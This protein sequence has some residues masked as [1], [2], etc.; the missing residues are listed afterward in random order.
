LAQGS[1]WGK[2][3]WDLGDLPGQLCRCWC[4]AMG[5]IASAPTSVLDEVKLFQSLDH[6]DRVKTAKAMTEKTYEP[7]EVIIRQN[8][9][10]DSFFVLETGT[11]KVE[12]DGTKVAELGHHEYFGEVALLRDETR[13]A[14]V[15]AITKVRLR[16]ISRAQFDE[17]KLKEKLRF[18]K[19][20]AVGGRGGDGKAAKPPSS[21]TP[22]ERE[23]MANA[24]KSNANLKAMF[25]LDE[26][27]AKINQ[28]IDVMWSEKVLKGKEIMTQGD[29]TAD[30]FY[31]VM[32]GKFA[33]QQTPGTGAE[34]GISV[35]QVGEVGP[36]GSFGE[37]ALMYAARRAATV[38]AMEDSSVMII[39]RFNFKDILQKSSTEDVE[40]YIGYLN[41]AEFLVSLK[42]E[43]KQLLARAVT[44]MTFKKDELILQEGEE[45][46]CFYILIEGTV[47]CLISGNEVEELKAGSDKADKIPFFGEKAL[48]NNE[49]RKATVKVTSQS[50]TALVVD[51]TSFDMLVGP[52]QALNARGKA[53]TQVVEKVTPGVPQKQF[54]LILRQNLKVLGLLGCGGFGTV[55]LVEHIKDQQTYALKGLS[56]GYVVKSGMQQSVMSEKNVQLQCNSDFII[57]LFETYN[58]QQN[59]YLLLEL[60]L[61]GELYATYNRKGLWGQEKHAQFYVAGTTFAFEHLHAK[62]IIFRDLKPENLLLNEQGRVKLTDMGLAKVVVGKTYTTCGTPDYFAPELIA[63]KGHTHAVDWWTLGILTFELLAGHPPFESATPMQI[64]QKVTRGIGK[65]KFPA[66]CKGHAESLIK[67]LCQEK[68]SD[69]LPMKRGEKGGETK[70]IKEHLW[71]T[72]ADFNWEDMKS[73]KMKPPYVPVV[74]S[75]KDMANFCARKE[76]RPPQITYTDDKSGWDAG[77]A[78]SK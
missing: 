12:V 46:D 38:V 47:K 57:Q 56:K 3:I 77:F 64:Y 68:P 26:D 35:V 33:V 25:K 8:E 20:G 4:I 55:D 59:L 19:R 27:E 32:T 31:I 50:A 11:V 34:K 39:D 24:L 69:R 67:G 70:A 78:T 66:K 10:G 76:D 29:L 1:A 54:G 51:R 60:A 17:L 73:H 49:T 75:K 2:E 15:T 74:K 53:G 13:S 44:E 14:T 6:G 41:K 61:G 7:G 42:D 37:L 23:L 30:Y 22:K 52:L 72:N 43:E 45:G 28:M 18:P 21:K 65:V 58:G 16:T 9:E 36:G 62:K 5:C 48:L 40:K 71:F 63:S